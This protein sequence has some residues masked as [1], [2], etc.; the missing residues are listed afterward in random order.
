MNLFSYI[1]THDTGF[2]PNPFWDCCTCACCKPEIRRVATEGDLVI[3]LS[4]KRARNRVVYVMRVTRRPITFEDYW[5]DPTFAAK[6]PDWTSDSS[7]FCCGDNIYRPLSKGATDPDDFQQLA[8]RH[9]N[10]DGTECREKKE[11]DLG[12]KRVLVSTDFVYYGAKAILLPV[13]F[14][15]LIVGRG[16]KRFPHRGERRCQEEEMIADFDVFFRGLPRGIQGL[17][18]DWDEEPRKWDRKEHGCGS[19]RLSRDGGGTEPRTCS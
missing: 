16:H 15:I 14:H 6:K 1:V 9:S 11:L 7:E 3:G 13:Q 12:G 10:F 19:K 17:P 18:T 8:S 2:A 4:P 5:N